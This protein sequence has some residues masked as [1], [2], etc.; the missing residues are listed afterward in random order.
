MEWK[1]IGIFLTFEPKLA[2]PVRLHLHRI[3]GGG[4]GGG[5]GGDGEVREEGG[6][7]DDGGQG[8]RQYEVVRGGEG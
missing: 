7:V 4:G 8:V 1:F 2:R 3:E 6:E 5:E